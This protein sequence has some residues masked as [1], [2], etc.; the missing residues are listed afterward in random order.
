MALERLFAP[1]TGEDLIDRQ[2][3]IE[4]LLRNFRNIDTPLAQQFALIGSRRIGKTSIL[5]EVYRRMKAEPWENM[6]I[7]IWLDIGQMVALSRADPVEFA[8]KF[9]AAFTYDYVRH[10]RPDLPVP[11]W[12]NMTLEQIHDL[13]E[14]IGDKTLRDAAVYLMSEDGRRNA[15]PSAGI[16]IGH[17]VQNEGKRFAI[18]V[19]EVQD[20][21][22]LPGYSG[23]SVLGTFRHSFESIYCLHVFTGSAARIMSCDVFGYS[24]PLHGRVTE[25]YLDPLT[26]V[27]DFALMDKLGR[28]FGLEWEDDAKLLLHELAGGYPFYTTCVTTRIAEEGV[29]LV[30]PRIVET[31][32]REE[33]L[34]GRM[35]LE[36]VDRTDPQMK[37]MGDAETAVRILRAIVQSESHIVGMG[38]LKHLPGFSFEVLENLARAD[39]IRL[40]GVVARM[41]DPA[42]KAW[43]RDVYLPLYWEKRPEE[44]AISALSRTIGRLVNDVGRLFEAKVAAVMWHFRGQTVSGEFFGRPDTAL[45]LPNLKEV[46]TRVRFAGPYDHPLTEP[47]EIDVLG[48]YPWEGARHGHWFV[49]CKYQEGPPTR[50]DLERLLHKRDLFLEAYFDTEIKLWL[51]TRHPLP[52]PLREWA[53]KRDLYFSSE[54]DLDRLWK[55]LRVAAAEGGKTS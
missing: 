22:L 27:D 16:A 4:R 54:E 3:I 47:F 45:T 34:R 12:E 50:A 32:F 9:L 10:E 1:V 20:L 15:P 52:Q 14:A 51:C 2:E 17:I 21:F 23:R 46:G 25:V 31:A 29:A 6:P 28:E 5:Q 49:E 35:R 55:T 40:N 13:A 30:T 36:F 53:E 24:S 18:I 44:A 33:L 8:T 7:P 43:L 11:L 19:D 37:A 26:P 41:L 48:L 42:Y 38:D 39:L